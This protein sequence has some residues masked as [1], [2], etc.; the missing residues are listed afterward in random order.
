MQNNIMFGLCLILLPVVYS[1]FSEDHSKSLPKENIF[2]F[3]SSR[4]MATGDLGEKRG[5]WDK[6]GYGDRRSELVGID[7]C[8]QYPTLCLLGL[9]GTDEQVRE[10]R[11]GGLFFDK[12]GYGDRR[13]LVAKTKKGFW[14]KRGYGD[15]RQLE[16]GNC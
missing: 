9:I 16:K 15:R 13:D 14:D 11:A 6:R 5:F 12:R 2:E 4:N 3:A 8:N 10:A 1:A 7:I